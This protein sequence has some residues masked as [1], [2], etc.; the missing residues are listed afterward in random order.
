M[1]ATS[2]VLL[3]V[4]QCAAVLFI[5][6]G[7]PLLRGLRAGW[8]GYQSPSMLRDA[9]AWHMVDTATGKDLIAIGA[10]LAP[11]ALVLWLSSVQTAVFALACAGWLAVG[12][13]GILLHGI[14]L[15][16]RYRAVHLR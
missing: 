3:F 2:F 11:L 16:A 10:T 7:V 6:L 8:S 14:V 9:V 12:A 1:A 15:M 4:F 13:T 5:A